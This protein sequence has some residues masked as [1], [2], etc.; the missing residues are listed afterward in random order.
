MEI[1]QTYILTLA[2]TSDEPVTKGQFISMA[3]KAMGPLGPEANRYAVIAAI[4]ALHYRGMLKRVKKDAYRSSMLGE[5]QLRLTVP[6][7]KKLILGIE[8]GQFDKPPKK[9]KLP[10]PS[11]P[12]EPE[13]PKKKPE[14]EP[15]PKGDEEEEE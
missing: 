7:M 13:A 11:L 9:K 5:T 6:L 14:T 4:A 12:L 2:M 8:Q 1:L 15:A 3:E 10:P